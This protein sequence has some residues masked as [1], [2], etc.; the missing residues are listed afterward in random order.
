MR[1]ENGGTS[2]V[3]DVGMANCGSSA[4]MHNLS[5]KPAG[6]VALDHGRAY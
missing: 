6:T 2:T 5:W 1:G 4:F 3:P